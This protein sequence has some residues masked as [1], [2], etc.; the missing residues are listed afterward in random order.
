MGAD[1]RRSAVGRNPGDVHVDAH[2][3]ERDAL[4]IEQAA[5]LLSLR[6]GSVRPD[7]PL[8]WDF[9]SWHS[10]STNPANRGASGQRSP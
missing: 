2:A 5:L 4:G 3:A 7:D 10:E 9:G 1:Y 8:P 6:E